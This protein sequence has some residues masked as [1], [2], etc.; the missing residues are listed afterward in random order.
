VN[1]ALSDLVGKPPEQ[2]V[3]VSAFDELTHPDDRAADAAAFE[4]LVAGRRDRDRHEKRF[5]LADGRGVWANLIF[6]LLRDE[7]G[8][9]QF[10]LCMAEDIT[11]RRQ[12]EQALRE[13]EARLRAIFD[14]ADLTISLADA[15]TGSVVAANCALL[16]LVGRAPEELAHVSTFDALTHPDDREADA[17]LYAE[18]AAGKR[19]RYRQEKRYLLDD[20]RV[21]WTSLIFTLL[22]DERGE[23]QFVLCMGEDVTER[24]AAEA[25]RHESEARFQ[26]IFDNVGVGIALN[27]L[28]GNAIETN[29]AYQ[30]MLGCTAD[31]LSQ[32]GMFARLTHPDDRDADE[33]LYN[34]LVTGKRSRY[35]WQEKRYLLR[36]GRVVWADLKMWLLRDAE[37][38]P[39]FVLGLAEDVTER[40]RAE[41]T[42]ARLETELRQAQKLEA[43][44]QLAGGVA[45]D[46]NNLL[47]A[48]EGYA[49]FALLALPDGGDEARNDLEEILRTA[50]RATE[51]TRQLLAFGRKQVL[52]PQVLGLDAVVHETERMLRRL[53]GEHIELR[54]SLDAEHGHVRV[55]PGQLEQVLVNLAINARD[56]MRSGGI[57]TIETRN[58]DLGG[59]ES[60]QAELLPPGPYVMLTVSDTGHGMDAE[61][62]S[63]AFEPFFT[64]KDTGEGTGLGLSTVYGIVTQSGGSISLESKPGEGATCTILLPRIEAP[65]VPQRDSAPS[66]LPR[67]SE[68]VLVVEDEEV[69]R[70]LVSRMLE[71]Q[72]Y[73]V[74]VAATAEEALERFEQAG[75]H[76]DLLLTDLVMPGGGG[77]ELAEELHARAP[78]LAVLTMSGYSKESHGGD[79][80][81]AGPFIEKPFPANRLVRLVREVLDGHEGA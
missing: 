77:Q 78:D 71:R 37:G 15:A 66:G 80:P 7:H 67:G 69:V 72:G 44:G 59:E 30:Q 42:H 58:V 10:V 19:E 29:R 11:E 52:Q 48:I 53:I 13:S 55:D 39:L 27:D 3:H 47:T 4:E 79:R 73:E 33:A 65:A 18:L 12:A 64:R 36:D 6:S 23:P 20:G 63:R 76:V 68:T 81:V 35:R 32:L 46:F 9:P 38:R 1:R 56:A 17:E 21:V 24:H 31:E 70:R 41:E 25:A 74:L 26:A 61:T 54:V 45:H 2:L 60:M 14:E 34:E 57:L 22:R 40:K 43:I 49:E 51:L 75:G 8:E 16:D 28:E 62:V 50:G 5:L